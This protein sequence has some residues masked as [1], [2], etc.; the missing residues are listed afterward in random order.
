MGKQTQSHSPDAQS[1]DMVAVLAA[2]GTPQSVIA[3]ALKISEPTLRKHY[4]E[5]LDEGTEIANAQV[6]QTL[7]RMATS[8][9]EPAATFFWLK[10]RA[11]WRETN[12]VELSGGL[13]VT[14][15]LPD[16]KLLEEAAAIVERRKRS[17]EIASRACSARLPGVSRQDDPS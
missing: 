4:R 17:A 9:Q 1:R 5:E 10:T 11:G 7:F 6:V 12:K 15:G 14:P 3:R 2:G 16:D 8:G 13:T